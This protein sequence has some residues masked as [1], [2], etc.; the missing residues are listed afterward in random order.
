MAK[1]KIK[2]TTRADSRKPSNTHS[3]SSSA[4]KIQ[5]R[6]HLEFLNDAQRDAWSSFD[7]HDVLFLLGP[8][9]CG[10]SHLAC[11]FAI[12]EILAKKKEKIVLTRPIIEAGEALGFLPGTMDEKVHPYM[13]PM[14]DCISRTVGREGPQREM[15]DKSLELAPIAYMREVSF[16]Q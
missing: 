9:G 7:K 15:I 2:R 5:N 14:Y 1:K 13:L 12:N 3:S 4:S 11:A 16:K 10:K 8:A 6:F